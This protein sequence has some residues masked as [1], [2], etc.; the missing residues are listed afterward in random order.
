MPRQL[1]LDD[2]GEIMNSVNAASL[3]FG[4]YFRGGALL[5]G[6]SDQMFSVMV[7]SD[8]KQVQLCLGSWAPT[9]VFLEMC[10]VS[11]QTTQVELISQLI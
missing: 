1:M 5:A 4:I 10:N 9:P 6:I 11:K 8:Y 7:L 3:W 2:L